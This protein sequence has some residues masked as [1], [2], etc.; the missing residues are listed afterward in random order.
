MLRQCPKLEMFDILD[1]PSYIRGERR[2]QEDYKAWAYVKEI[3]NV[4]S[5]RRIK[6]LKN[7]NRRVLRSDVVFGTRR[8]R[9]LGTRKTLFEL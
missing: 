6:V 8:H 1:R 9:N 5:G 7:K 2:I 3:T 4:V